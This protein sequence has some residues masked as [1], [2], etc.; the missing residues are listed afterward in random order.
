MSQSGTADAP[1]LQEGAGRTRRTK[2]EAERDREW[3]AWIARF[4]FVTAKELAFRFGVSERQARVR[5]GHLHRAGVIDLQRSHIAEAYAASVT[6]A[7][8]RELG[9]LRPAKMPRADVQRIHELAVV[10]LAAQLELALPALVLR[11]ERDGQRL[12]AETG[13][14]YSVDVSDGRGRSA[15]RWPD[16][17]VEAAHGSIAIEIEFSPKGSSRL[18]A[19]LRAYLASDL[20]E[21]RIYVISPALARR[22]LRLEQQ[23]RS[24]LLAGLEDRLCRIRVLPWDGALEQDKQAIREAVAPADAVYVGRARPTATPT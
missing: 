22:I 3:L 7:G 17:M 2:Q 21:V 20:A 24:R 15:R 12:E 9:D 1:R 11:T 18:S 19:I 4:R 8:R 10:T 23:E 14:R 6:T 5:I 13:Q 16:L